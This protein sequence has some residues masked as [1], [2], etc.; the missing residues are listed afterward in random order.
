MTMHI[1]VH[2]PGRWADDEE[3]DVSEA[4]PQARQPAAAQTLTGSPAE[5]ERDIEAT[6]QRLADTLDDLVYR[7]K[8]STIVSRKVQEIKAH[9]VDAEGSVRTDNV[10]KAAVAVG[11]VVIFL[12][13]VRKLSTGK[14]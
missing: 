1:P 13:V 3:D 9:F 12:V 10:V 6:R 2:A 5:L 7:V 14:D 8:P 11:G 4:S